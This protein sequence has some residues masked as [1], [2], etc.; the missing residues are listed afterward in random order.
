M[1]Y[2]LIS[3]VLI[4]NNLQAQTLLEFNKLFVESEDKWVAFR[5]DKDQTYTYGFIYIDSQAGL[6][7]NYEGKFKVSPKGEF[8]PEA[9]DSISSVKVRLNPNNVRVAFIPSTKFADLKIKPTPE[10]L[11]FYKTDTTSIERLYRWGYLY[12]A[13]NQPAKA[14]T[15][16]EKGRKINPKFAGLEFELAYSYN[17]LQ[18]F[19]KSIPVLQSAIATTPGDCYLYKELSYAEMHL[20]QFQQAAETCKKGINICSEKPIKS[21]IA[22]N[23]AYQYFKLKD[24]PN[25]LYWAKETKKWATKDDQFMANIIRMEKEFGK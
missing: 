4:A 16:L 2:L 7:F 15:Y 3:L 24:K 21:E 6:T 18:Q 25:F 23:M 9:R 8:V 17:A 20:G 19:D 22:N 1:K 10:W 12:N 11:R 5:E 13:W 14:L